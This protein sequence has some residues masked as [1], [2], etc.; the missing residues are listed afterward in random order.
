MVAGQIAAV[1]VLLV[2]VAEWLHRRRCLRVAVLVSGPTGRPPKWTAAAPAVRTLAAAGMAWGLV[3]LCLVEPKVSRADERGELDFRRLAIVLDVSPSMQLKDSGAGRL[4]T[5]ARR[6]SDVLANMLRRI[7][8][9]QV[10]V[11][12]IA[13]YSGAKAVVEDTRDIEV[14]RNIL[15]DLPLEKAF[16][17][18]KTELLAGLRAAAEHAGRWPK[19]STTL[20]VVTD[21]VTVP[22]SEFPTMPDSVSTSLVI[23]VGDPRVGRYIDGHQSRQDAFRLRGIARRLGG[24]YCDC[25][26]RDLPAEALAELATALPIRADAQVGRRELAL[27]VTALGGALLALLPVALALFGIG[28]K[29]P[30]ARTGVRARSREVPSPTEGGDT[31][32]PELVS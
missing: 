3:T 31:C 32:V 14:V 15:N 26:E 21:G 8:L 6:A 24:T 5:R 16:E 20:L 10:R 29:S 1:V 7:L 23:G 27:A 11:S 22:D 9:D 25:N 28:A 2:G 18:G 17:H 30:V 19:D 13:V 4:Q 12:V